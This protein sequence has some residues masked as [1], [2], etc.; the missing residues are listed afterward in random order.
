MYAYRWKKPLNVQYSIFVCYGKK[1]LQDKKITAKMITFYA[2]SEMEA[3][4]VSGH[5]C[6]V[7]CHLYI[8]KLFEQ[9]LYVALQSSLPRVQSPPTHTFDTYNSNGEES[10][11]F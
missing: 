5:L 3:Y 11:N 1:D 6:K 10:W 7:V 8:H 2:L 4:V 9:G